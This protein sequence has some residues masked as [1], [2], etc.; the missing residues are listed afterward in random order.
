M[1]LKST[2][3]NCDDFF[4]AGYQA[5]GVKLLFSGK[6]LFNAF[7]EFDESGHNWMVNMSTAKPFTVV[8]RKMYIL[9]MHLRK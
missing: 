1:N 6:R 9:L 5:N 8:L 3:P 7:C 4:N 2:R